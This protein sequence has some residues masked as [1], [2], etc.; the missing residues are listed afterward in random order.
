MPR[1]E[2]ET[3]EELASHLE[4]GGGL[5]DAVFQGLNLTPFAETLA[6]TDLRGAVF[7]GCVI[8][9]GLLPRLD[10]SAVFPEPAGLPF[11]AFR[12]ALY[13]PEELLGAYEIGDHESY[14]R[15]LD[16]RVFAYYD[17]TGGA[18]PLDVVEA[19]GRRLHDLSITDALHEFIEG[20]RVVAIMGGHSM[21]RDDPAY[22]ATARISRVLT[23]RGYFMVSGGGPGAMEATHLGA[24]FVDREDEELQEAVSLLSEAPLY[25]PKGPWLDTALTVVERFPPASPERAASL[26]IPTW[27][28]GHEP[29]NCFALHIAKYFENS[30]REEGV[31]AIAKNGVIF[32]P[33]SAGTIQEV[34]QDAAQNH[35]NSFG[36]S[37]P[38]VFFGVD[39][40]TRKKPVYPLL[41]KLAEGRGYRDL[42]SI[43]DSPE[44]IV[45]AIEK[46]E[47]RE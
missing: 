42:L 26:G 10:A 23:G 25:K 45:A 28:Y 1:R 15:T 9:P 12:G 39:Y 37:S 30:V 41:E 46:F 18:N 35:Y 36:A 7:L 40:W 20:R 34:F 14:A 3:E 13:T 16:G 11:Q 17:A 43:S 31:L 33:G 21:R 22:L 29:P 44:E 19:L 5:T 2:F 8:P 32:T 38:M 24:W 6:D 4:A 27:L 47:P